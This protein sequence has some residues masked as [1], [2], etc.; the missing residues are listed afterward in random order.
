MAWPKKLL[1]SEDIEKLKTITKG[2]STTA[3]G[4]R[5]AAVRAYV[6]HSA[7]E[8]AAYF[9]T[10]SETIIRWAS[11]FHSN[12]PKVLETKR[13]GHRQMKLGTDV[14]NAVRDWLDGTRTMRGIPCIGRSGVCAWRCRLYS[15]SGFQRR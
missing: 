11:K 1:T 15:P 8:V 5:L 2:D 3:I 6:R 9:D 14:Q 10:E 7:E 13:R 12:G 4:Y